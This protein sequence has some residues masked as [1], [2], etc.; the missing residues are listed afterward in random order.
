MVMKRLSMLVMM[1]IA[2]AGT[3]VVA[4]AQDMP[5]GPPGGPGG[6]RFQMPSFAELDKNKDKKLSRDEFPGM[7]PPQVFD[8]LD[9]NKDG[10]VDEAEF[11]RS[12]GRMMGGG[13]R[14]GES[15][16]KFMDANQDSKI[17]REEFAKITQI[18]D[19]LDGDKSGDLS[20]EELNR[21]FQAVN[22]AQTQ[23]TGGVDVNNLFQNTDKNKDGKLTTD[24]MTD[25]RLFKALDLNK[26]GSVPRDEAEQ[27]LKQINERR[28][29]R[30]SQ[31]QSQSN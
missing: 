10:F 8:R 15:L 4:S 18:F 21:F 5:P 16:S 13:P 23:A 25:E 7:V 17:T 1:L 29:R 20:Q 11:G 6:M 24:E 3:A 22:D 2:V 26:D 19:A 28:Q 9:E 31:P 12:R 14:F 30:Q 27:A